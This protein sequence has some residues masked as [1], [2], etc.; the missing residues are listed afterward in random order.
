MII[1][2]GYDGKRHLNDVQI[3]DLENNINRK[4]M[5]GITRKIQGKYLYI[6]S[7]RDALLTLLKI[8]VFDYYGNDIAVG[9]TVKHG[10]DR[11]PSGFP[12]AYSATMNFDSCCDD[13]KGF[14]DQRKRGNSCIPGS[15][16]A[17]TKKPCVDFVSATDSTAYPSTDA[18]SWISIHLNEYNKQYENPIHRIS[19]L[20]GLSTYP[21]S[22]NNIHH[23]PEMMKRLKDAVLFITDEDIEE[24]RDPMDY[25]LKWTLNDDPFQEY[26]N[27]R[28]DGYIEKD[29]RQVCLHRNLGSGCASISAKTAYGSVCHSYPTLEKAFQ[30]CL[31]LP[32]ESENYCNTIT[33]LKSSGKTCFS[34]CSENFGCSTKIGSAVSVWRREVE[35][36]SPRSNHTAVVQNGVMHV[37][38]GW[39]GQVIF[40]D[41][42]N[43]DVTSGRWSS[44]HNL[45]LKPYPRFSHASVLINGGMITFGGHSSEGIV[46]SSK[47]QCK[48]AGYCSPFKAI[49]VTGTKSAY[50]LRDGSQSYAEP[51][52]PFK[53]WNDI[54]DELKIIEKSIVLDNAYHDGWYTVFTEAVGEGYGDYRLDDSNIRLM[55]LDGVN[56]APP[57]ECV[58]NG[59]YQVRIEYGSALSNYVQFTVPSGSNIF[60]QQINQ[61]IQLSG[62]TSSF[63]EFGTTAKFCHACVKDGTRFGG[64]CWAVTK[65]NDNN[66]Q[67]G[68]NGPSWD[69]IGVYYGGK[70]QNA[71]ECEPWGGGFA[72][73]TLNNGQ[74]GGLP[75]VG[76]VIKV[77]CDQIENIVEV[78]LDDDATLYIFSDTR[79]SAVDFGTVPQYRY[80]SLDNTLYRDISTSVWKQSMDNSGNALSTPYYIR[81]SFHGEYIEGEYLNDATKND[82]VGLFNG[83]KGHFKMGSGG[84]NTLSFEIS[85]SSKQIT[86]HTTPNS[87]VLS[88]Y[89][90]DFSFN[91]LF[92]EKSE[93]SL[94]LRNDNILPGA[95]GGPY[96]FNVWK[97]RIRKRNQR[98]KY[99]LNNDWKGTFGFALMPQHSATVCDKCGTRNDL[100]ELLLY[101][102]EGCEVNCFGCLSHETCLICED[103]FYL[104]NGNCYPSDI[105]PHGIQSFNMPGK[106]PDVVC[107]TCSN[108]FSHCKGLTGYGRPATYVP[109]FNPFEKSTNL[110]TGNKDVFEISKINL[111]SV[112]AYTN[113]HVSFDIYPYS[114]S[115]G[116]NEIFRFTSSDNDCC[117]YL[118]KYLSVSFVPN[119]ENALYFDSG[120]TVE[121][122]NLDLQ[123][124]FGS[125]RDGNM[126]MHIPAVS[127]GILLNQWSKVNIHVINNVYT[128]AVNR[129]K[130]SLTTT[131]RYRRPVRNDHLNIHFG[132]DPE[133]VLKSSPFVA[134]G[135]FE[136]DVLPSK[137]F[138]FLGSTGLFSDFTLSFSIWTT[139]NKIYSKEIIRFSD[140]RSKS[141]VIRF[142]INGNLDIIMSENEQNITK[143]FISFKSS[144]HNL[145]DSEGWKHVLIDVHH[146]TLKA[147]IQDES[148]TNIMPEVSVTLEGSY[149]PYK[150]DGKVYIK[151]NFVE[152]D[153]SIGAWTKILQIDGAEYTPDTNAQDELSDTKG[154]RKMSDVDINTIPADNN[155]YNYYM[156]TDDKTEEE[157]VLYVRTKEEFQDTASVFGWKGSSPTALYD[158]C[159]LDHFQSITECIWTN[160]FFA[161]FGTGLGRSCNQWQFDDSSGSK[162]IQT[163]NT[164]K[165]CF[166][167]GAQSSCSYLSV[168]NQLRQN[169]KIYKLDL[170]IH[171]NFTGKY[172]EFFN[173]GASKSYDTL[174]QTCNDR[175]QRFCT[176]DEICPNGRFRK[177]IGGEHNSVDMWLPIEN[178]EWVQIGKGAE[179]WC[180]KLSGN[181]VTY[182]DADWATTDTNVA[183]KQVYACCNNIADNNPKYLYIGNQNF[184]LKDITYTP[185]STANNGQFAYFTYNPET[186]VAHDNH[187]G[188][189]TIYENFQL[190][191]EIKVDTKC[192]NVGQKCPILRFMSKSADMSPL[193]SIKENSKLLC[194]NVHTECYD[195]GNG[196]PHNY[197]L[198]A[199]Y[200]FASDGWQRVNIIY[201]NIQKNKL[202]LNYPNDAYF[203]EL[204]L[205]SN[206]ITSDGNICKIPRRKKGNVYLTTPDNSDYDYFSAGFD[207][208]PEV[209]KIKYASLNFNSN[210]NLREFTYNPV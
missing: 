153:S 24:L 52:F 207:T 168:E 101:S 8:K 143:D 170:R 84:S 86:I 100:S 208:M 142:D 144:D 179:G 35:L 196:N 131:R 169:V 60:E 113:Y 57:E 185:T 177:P 11:C 34:Y 109:S 189:T 16:E 39:D 154:D 63:S 146:N 19:I 129:Y 192:N 126:I 61:N 134:N 140:G 138:I 71:N 155:G 158:F 42:W 31:H 70:A 98:R 67:C 128:V 54:D 62:V 173:D 102:T 120:Q 40:D 190:S 21:T 166:S 151:S 96:T 78:E 46:P 15:S 198:C 108:G 164:N 193:I 127:S 81:L 123:V 48:K 13:N 130:T 92:L 95:S 156:F 2:G 159:Y 43:F 22:G 162:C 88:Y 181:T 135:P 183:H 152:E 91:A 85:Y 87:I 72:G 30:A 167:H 186:S 171:S 182:S 23:S 175:R 82:F 97:S 141:P 73:D 149:R 110:L 174:E 188:Y 1:F 64:S 66:R 105:C 197:E 180:Q 25:S 125:M 161:G 203:K 77:K 119:N 121:K 45:E 178:D 12:Y 14:G 187:I 124:S 33:Y 58:I 89:N 74:K 199:D 9:K 205:L 137:N 28:S 117:A 122:I 37:Y 51:T 41:L 195:F 75:S 68:C 6:H 26:V 38:G 56:S 118:D 136:A 18:A 83:K 157:L 90:G 32:P 148:N 165:R 49:H 94:T 4:W 7:E 114:K 201:D 145:F 3:L 107:V 204:E 184:G 76:V 200:E 104:K 115:I 202:I 176:Y 20:N 69:G 5:P 206:G 50:L 47:L 29:F 106:L 17:C 111:G 132:Q 99:H 10:F 209:R 147:S 133:Q 55:N 27:D 65:D 160:R 139:A 44:I 93:P 191:F 210:A 103:R 194:V 79:N 116:R 59:N 53:F 163:S 172:M 36:P 150:Q 80:D 112:I